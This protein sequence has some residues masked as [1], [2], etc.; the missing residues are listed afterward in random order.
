M[1]WQ[2][3]D[4]SY[5][6]SRRVLV[7][8]IV[9]VTPDSFSDGGKFFDIER[10]ADH[11]LE[12]IAQ[13]ADILDIGG[14]STRPGSDAVSVEEE[15]RRVVPVIERLAGKIQV[16]ISIDTMKAEVARQ[17][18]AAGAQIINDVTALRGDP[19]MA[20]VAGETKAAV[21][22]M[23]MIGTPKTMQQEPRYGDVVT[24]VGEFLRERMQAAEAAGI[25]RERIALDPG[26]GFGKT[27]EHNVELF[28]RMGELAALGR[29]LLIGPSRKAFLG[30]LLGGAPPEERLEGTIAAVVA[31][32][33]AGA[34]I[35]RVHDVGPVAK[36]VK[37]AQELAEGR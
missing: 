26:I 20:G 25:E 21:V 12:L 14:E 29:P 19:K 11:A 33:C 8:G 7:M 22:L 2:L 15:L 18:V 16:P 3:I 4:R 17:A 23:H 34:R 36:A 5:D 37:V 24:E 35:V 32:I 9:N 6:L 10:A 13:G 31:S 28:R 27:L 30:K 1:R